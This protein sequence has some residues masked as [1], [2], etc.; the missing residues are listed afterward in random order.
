VHC[1]FIARQQAVHAES[2]LFCQFRPSVCLSL[3]L[4]SGCIISTNAHIVAFNN[5]VGHHCSLTVACDVTAVEPISVQHCWW[6]R[7]L[8]QYANKSW[9][10][11]PQERWFS[12]R[13]V[14]WSLRIIYIVREKWLW[15][16][17]KI[18]P[19][20][21][22]LEE[23]SWVRR[24]QG[25]S[26]PTVDRRQFRWMATDRHL[27]SINSSDLAQSGR[28]QYDDRHPN[29]PR[30]VEVVGRLKTASCDNCRIYCSLAKLA[31]IDNKS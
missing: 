8:K 18:D 4:S 9:N 17:N 28:E 7:I 21:A 16:S 19:V 24:H 23:E 5:L 15:T 12:T 6:R 3:R 30:T 20:K 25:W 10:Y 29:T 22:K 2:D 13:R 27:F 31:Y 1:I 26:T 11:K 14:Q